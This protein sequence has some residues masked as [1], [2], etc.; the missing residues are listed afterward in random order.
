MAEERKRMFT[1]KATMVSSGVTICT[2]GVPTNAEETDKRSALAIQ[3][4]IEKQTKLGMWP[5]AT[6]KQR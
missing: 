1:P 4:A 3:A 6:S 2:E 5:P